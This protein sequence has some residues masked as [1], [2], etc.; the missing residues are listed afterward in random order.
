MPS[1]AD[2][3]LTI[4]QAADAH[5]TGPDFITELVAAGH[6]DHTRHDDQL[7]IP[8]SALIAY[9][10]AQA[11][12]VTTPPRLSATAPADHPIASAA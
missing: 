9:A 5:G 4:D 12:P 8:E 1:P 10:I 6:L 3:H 11:D 2:P 7:R